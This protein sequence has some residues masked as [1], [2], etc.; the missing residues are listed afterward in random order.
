M[1][2]NI[3]NYIV[4]GVFFTEEEA[5]YILSSVHEDEEDTFLDHKNIVLVSPMTDISFVYGELMFKSK[6]GRHDDCS[7]PVTQVEHKEY[8]MDEN[9]PIEIVK[10]FSEGKGKLGTFVFT[11]Y[12]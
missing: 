6:D 7:I 8:V 4:N 11:C 9:T 2:V 3:R 5:E 10:A 1:G 12:S